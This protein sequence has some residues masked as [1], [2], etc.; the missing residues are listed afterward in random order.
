[1]SLKGTSSPRRKGRA[2]ALQ[3]LYESDTAH[4]SAEK[5][6]ERASQQGRLP[7][8]VVSFG[9]ELVKGVHN[10]REEIDALIRRHAPAWPVE[11]LPAI[12]RNVLRIALFEMIFTEE[13]P[14]KVAINEAIELA[15]TFGG[16]TSPKFVNGV[17]GSV[18]AEQDQQKPQV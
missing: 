2:I 6:I 7:S 1:M 3:A 12:D 15:K 11:Q 17:L 9:Q 10:H 14:R 16:E 13:T 8:S 5:A 4:H 18:A